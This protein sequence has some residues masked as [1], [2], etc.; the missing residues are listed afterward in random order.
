MTAHRYG[1]NSDGLAQVA[2]NL[3]R[4]RVRLPEFV[5]GVNLGKN[6]TSI[7]AVSDYTV[8]LKAFAH[9]GSYFV[10]NISSP[11]TPGLRQ[12]QNRQELDQLLG[13]IQAY[14]RTN[15]E[16]IHRP[17]LVK[18]AP[19]LTAEQ[20]HEIAE[21]I[22]KHKVD[23]LIVSNTTIR[24]DLVSDAKMAAES[25]GLSGQ[26][27]RDISTA[28]IGRMYKLTKGQVPIVGVGGVFTGADAYDKIRAG[29]SLVQLY[30]S[31]AFEGPPIVNRIKRDLSELIELVLYNR[32]NSF[33]IFCSFYSHI[34]CLVEQER[35]LF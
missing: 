18:L 21:L 7:D 30:S 24:R 9:L 6:K 5:I 29:A 8:G 13:A 2:H 27:V 26:A 17:L 11:N 10:I 3:V 22:V 34:F 1:F 4:A 15:K 19:D 12:L 33:L 16:L 23:G 14:R 28:L 31:L 20:E 32:N 35:R 25:G